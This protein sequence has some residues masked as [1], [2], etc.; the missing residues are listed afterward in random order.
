MLVFAV[1]A[2]FCK[3][4]QAAVSGAAAA[5]L[6]LAAPGAN[7]SPSPEGL[8][9]K[10][11]IVTMNDSHQVIPNGRMLVNGGTIM[12]VWPGNLPPPMPVGRAKVVDAGPGGLIFPGLINLH[13]HP[14]WDV[15]P[16]WPAPSS[17]AQPDFGR[18]TGREPYGNRC[19]WGAGATPACL[20]WRPE[21]HDRLVSNPG[22][23]LQA[24]TVGGA[25]LYEQ[26]LVYAEAQSALGGETTM[27]GGVKGKIIRDVELPN[28]GRDKIRSR[29][30]PRS[31]F[32]DKPPNWAGTLKGALAANKVDAWL[33]HL[34]EGV[35]DGDRAPGDGY[36]SRS[37]LAKLSQLGLLTSAT[38][39]VHGVALEQSDFAKL[40]AADAKLVWSPLSNLLLY[41]RTA[42]VAQAIAAGV[43]VSLGT[44]WT[45]SGSKTLLDELKV[46]DLALRDPRIL[47][48]SRRHVRALASDEALDRALVDMVTRN[49]ARTLRWPEV[50]TIAPQ[51]HADLL[52]LRRPAKTPTGGMP[53]TPYRNLIDATTRD[54]R[55]VLVEG[56]PVAGDVDAMKAAG[57]TTYDLVRSPR[58][59]VKAIAY[60]GVIGLQLRLGAVA[61]SL[62]T[63]LRALGGDG[64]HLAS[65]PPPK[66]TKF[67]F[68]HAHWANADCLKLL[69]AACGALNE[70]AFR[71]KMLW[72]VFGRTASGRINAERIE[73]APLLT[74][75]DP[76]F[77]A[78]LEGQRLRDGRPAVR[79]PPFRLYPAN[80]NQSVRRG[81]PFIGFRVRWYG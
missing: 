11:T 78:V 58:K 77:F 65:G 36:S 46:A 43:T 16:I 18:P 40:K 63:A 12:A 31:I 28:F 80:V 67:S 6:L 48:Q 8:L 33:V 52:V 54:V 14:S 35:R 29:S 38:V 69:G 13:D 60:R 9:L 56:K 41:G 59:Y 76:L 75:D 19:Q 24:L 25:S 23:A 42:N 30:P 39:I 61:N 17:H 79:P 62:R 50:G 1:S 57:A 81:N 74:E 49:P 21:E 34:G 68:L 27:Q 4:V 72:H 45:P 55:L 64:A 5:A 70:A 53:D 2:S 20:R 73:L 3:G 32:V 44:D 47:G 71:D 66:P 51:L 22:D 7:S 15:L 26:A 10:G 37:E